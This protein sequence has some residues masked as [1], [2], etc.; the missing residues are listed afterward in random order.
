MLHKLTAKMKLLLLLLPA[1]IVMIIS[2]YTLLATVATSASP[3]QAADFLYPL[4]Q[5]VLRLQE[6]LGGAPVEQIYS[7]PTIQ[8][9]VDFLAVPE[10]NGLAAVPSRM[11]GD[12][13]DPG[14]EAR[15]GDDPGNEIAA[16]DDKSDSIDAADNDNTE[17]F[18]DISDDEDGADDDDDKRND[19]DDD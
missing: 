15:G 17:D 13:G 2:F 11:H 5:P 12:L 16:D 9:K 14:G 3:N 6:R 18:D 8:P 19:A 1:V 7:T 10:A 4:R